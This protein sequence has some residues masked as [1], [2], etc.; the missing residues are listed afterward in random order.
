MSLAEVFFQTCMALSDKL[1]ENAVGKY[2]TGEK[3]RTTCNSRGLEM[4]A[5]DISDFKGR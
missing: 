4:S 2:N 5:S 3:L 1:V